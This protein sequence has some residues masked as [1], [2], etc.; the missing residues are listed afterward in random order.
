M[1]TTTAAP[2]KI[3][4]G[5]SFLIENRAPSEI[6]TPEDL[7]DQH[8]LIAQTAREFVFQEVIPRLGEMEA[9]KPGLLREL[10]EKAAALGL[11]GTDVSQK[12]GGLELDK[13]SS[14]IVSEEMAR[15]GAWAATLGC[16]AG[17]GILPI[18]LFGTEAQ[19]ANYVPKLVTA[20]WIGAYC[21]SEATSA[22]DA[23]NART[24]AVLSADGRHYVLNGTKHWIT[25][26]GI[27][28]VYVVF[29]KVDGEKFTAFIV[30]GVFQGVSPGAEEHKMGIRGSSTTPVTLENVAVTVENVLGEVGKGHLIAF[31]ILNMGRL[32]LGAGCIGGARHLFA[33]A[34][35][36]AKE[37]EA[38]GHPIADFGLIK[39][40]LGEMAVRI[41][42]A[43]SMCY[44]TA[45][46]I[47]ELLEGVDQSA[48]EA[49]KKILKAL[50]QY[51]VECSILK[52]AGTEVLDFVSDETVQIYGGYGF[53]SDYPIERTYRDQRVNRIF[54]GTNEINRLL[55][56]DML[57]K[58]SMKGELGLIPA[59]Q[60]LMDEILGAP[61]L[62]GSFQDGLLAAE[63]QLLEGAKKVV[64]MVAGSALQRYM[65]ALADEQE[66]IAALSNLVMGVYAME[67]A[68]LRT[69]K[70]AGRSSPEDCEIEVAATRALIYNSVDNMESEARRALSRI[71]EGDTLRTQL[72][73]L[74][75]FLRRNPPDTIGLRRRVADHAIGLGRY[76]F[77]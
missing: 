60:H 23:M 54:E 44:R 55:I 8:R 2:K 50:E 26:G 74:R 29:A 66:I 14:I 30:E 58:R 46:M 51:A 40:K 16:Q 36:W 63:A 69:L 5:G 49:G 70:K 22:S 73:V 13:I 12:Y 62:D 38:F 47:D 18:A 72:A 75:R 52:V 6:F 28:D 11:C 59:A 39:E 20:E 10:L 1:A 25:N 15:D 19:K 64:L 61:A 31:N 65:Q 27:A 21:L 43:E 42:A 34:V 53:S 3:V 57:M 56:T 67:S 77:R 35:K 7:T 17:I 45:G 32:K 76:P 71:A 48:P 41:Y 9:K 4:K 33:E 24:K 68:L 37:R